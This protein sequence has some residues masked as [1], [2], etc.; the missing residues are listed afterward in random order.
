MSFI[1]VR[2]ERVRRTHQRQKQAQG[3]SG[4]PTAAVG[5]GEKPRVWWQ[6]LPC[7]PWARRRKHQ[8]RFSPALPDFAA[9]AFQRYFNINR[10]QAEFTGFPRNV[11]TTRSPSL[12]PLYGAPPDL[13]PNLHSMSFMPFR[14]GSLATFS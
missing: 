5:S 2:L 3:D 13:L 14:S 4:T 1:K 7:L 11:P 8:E 12:P 10:D 9:W 6:L